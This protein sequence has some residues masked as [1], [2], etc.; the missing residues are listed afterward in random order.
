MMRYIG[1][2]VFIL[3][4]T[5]VFFGFTPA[6]R[7]LTIRFKKIYGL[8]T[9]DRLLFDKNHIGEVE[10]VA[11]GKDGFFDVA[12]SVKSGFVNAATEHTVFTIADDQGRPG[13][14]AV[15]LLQTTTGGTV[16]QEGTVVIGAGDLPQSEK[17]GIYAEEKLNDLKR[18]LDRLQGEMH[19]FRNSE[20]YRELKRDLAEIAGQLKKAEKETRE[21]IQNELIPLLNRKL[22]EFKKK[23]E[24]PPPEE[25]EVRDNSG[26]E[27]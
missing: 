24:N 2:A 6:D 22:E 23:R 4:S 18:E 15:E 9:G 5:L 20:Q 17:P 25:R 21:K 12:V 16:L 19:R 27:V 26:L 13:K 1:K 3:L 11:Y 14:K 7:H 10:E 8:Q